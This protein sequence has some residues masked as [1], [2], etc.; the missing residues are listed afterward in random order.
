MATTPTK[1]VFKFPRNQCVACNRVISDNCHPVLVFG[2][3]DENLAGNF[4]NVTRI[5]L[6]ANDNFP[7]KI[8]VPCKT[9][10]QSAENFR[11]LCFNSRKEQESLLQ[12]RVKRGK[13]PGESPDAKRVSPAN[14]L[15]EC[16]QN[17]Q[18]RSEVNGHKVPRYRAILPKQTAE[19]PTEEPTKDGENVP[20]LKKYGY[21]N[22][23]VSRRFVRKFVANT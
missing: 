13:N 22:P 20:V 14:D 2:K 18:K 19:K 16:K 5:T 21:C 8:C 4:K 3:A 1:S 11:V 15:A 23:K 10:L 17:I 6:N 9:K 12:E 7:K